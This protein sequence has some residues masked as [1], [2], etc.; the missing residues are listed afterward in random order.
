MS[1]ATKPKQ[2]TVTQI[3]KMPSIIL[4]NI[5]TTKENIDGEDLKPRNPICLQKLDFCF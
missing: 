2:N 1:N 4:Q 3:V 5:S